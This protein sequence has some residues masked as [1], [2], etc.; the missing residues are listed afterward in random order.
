MSISKTLRSRYRFVCEYRQRSERVYTDLDSSRQ[1]CSYQTQ[2]SA[3]KKRLSSDQKDLQSLKDAELEKWYYFSLGQIGFIKLFSTMRS[4]SGSIC[5]P[6]KWTL[7]N[8]Y[9]VKEKICI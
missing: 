1:F 6:L 8:M 5:Q 7:A 2:T 4:L 3:S 9:F